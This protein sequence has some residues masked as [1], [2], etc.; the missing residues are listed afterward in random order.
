[1]RLVFFCVPRIKHR[2]LV[3]LPEYLSFCRPT[4]ASSREFSVKLSFVAKDY[5]VS[6]VL[7]LNDLFSDKLIERMLCCSSANRRRF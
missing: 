5:R 4:E 3:L 6:S 2:A 1:M 7:S